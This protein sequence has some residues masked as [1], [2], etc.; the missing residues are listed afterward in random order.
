MAYYEH[1]PIYKKALDMAVYFEKI[2][3][4]FSRY[5]KYTIGTGLRNISVEIVLKIAKINSLKD[6]N[7][8]LLGLREEIIKLKTLIH[9]AKEVRAFH[10][11]NSFETSVRCVNEIAMQMEGWLRGQKGPESARQESG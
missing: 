7:K 11:F 6:K 3:K 8:A 9:I 2:V 10:N 5:H 1:L 4:N